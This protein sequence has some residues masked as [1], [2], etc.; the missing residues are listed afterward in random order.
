MKEY[1]MMIC[2][3]IHRKCTF[4]PGCCGL[5]L[6]GFCSGIG[7][8]WKD[9]RRLDDDNIIFDPERSACALLVVPCSVLWSC[10]P[11]RRAD[12]STWLFRWLQLGCLGHRRFS[13]IVGNNFLYITYAYSIVKNFVICISIWTSLHASVWFFDFAISSKVI[14]TPAPSMNPVNMNIIVPRERIAPFFYRPV[15]TMYWIMQDRLPIRIHD[16]VKSTMVNQLAREWDLSLQVSKNTL[17]RWRPVDFE[18]RLP[19][20]GTIWQSG[21]LAVIVA[22]PW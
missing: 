15:S 14:F 22:E 16:Y 2:W 6:Y 18:T 17:Q 13:G 1:G 20:S 12:Y 5:R 19:R 7:M 8:F 9:P 11:A 3:C 10:Y 4:G 21:L